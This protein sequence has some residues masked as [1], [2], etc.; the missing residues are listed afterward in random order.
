MAK[1]ID[2][3]MRN[4]KQTPAGWACD[5]YAA[6]LIMSPEAAADIASVSVDAVALLDQAVAELKREHEESARLRAQV[7]SLLAERHSTNEALADMT[8]LL[9]SVPLPSVGGA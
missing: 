5:L 1:V 8:A 2:A 4:G 3:S 6:G 7:A 9:R